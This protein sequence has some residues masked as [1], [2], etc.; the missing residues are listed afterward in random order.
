MERSDYDV[1]VGMGFDPERSKLA[2]TKAKGLHDALEW[3][4]K[5]QDRPIEELRGSYSSGEQAIAGSSAHAS[6]GLDTDGDKEE[7]TG[8]AASLKCLD[9]GKLF[10][11]PA[12][13]E[14]HATRTEHQ[15]F[16][17][18][19]EVIK[20][21]TEEEKKSKLIELRERLAAKKEA[22]AKIDSQEAKRNEAIRR[23]KTQD[24]EQLKEV[25]RRK[26]QLKEV[27]KRKREKLED[28]Q[29]RERVKQQIKEQ[30]EARKRQ[31][32]KEKAAREGRLVTETTQPPKPLEPKVTTSH[33]ESRLQL[34]LADQPPL[35]KTLPANTTLFEVASVVEIARGF[36]PNSF[37]MTFPRKIFSKEK[38]FGLTLKEAGMVPSCSLLVN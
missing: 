12:R 26:E 3:L 33:S 34:R 6:G 22:Q 15:N 23:K 11:T 24:T 2:M 25:L 13:A 29:A 30:Q 1:L 36:A 20:P 21:L 14:F 38:D 27:E 5:N 7:T 9:C 16:E 8:T 10:S 28:L 35:V 31:A 19:T 17:E 32:E 18:S 37:T 4:D